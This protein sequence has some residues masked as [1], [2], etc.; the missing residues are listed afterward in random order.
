MQPEENILVF[1]TSWCYRIQFSVVVKHKNNLMSNEE[2]TLH[3]QEHKINRANI[4]DNERV[5][6]FTSYLTQFTASFYEQ[7]DGSLYQ[8]SHKL[9]KTR[10]REY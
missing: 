1:P 10:L 2:P 4:L 6:I 8:I 7:N 9:A 3:K 5:L